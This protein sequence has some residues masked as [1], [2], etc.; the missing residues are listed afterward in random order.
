MNKVIHKILQC[1][2]DGKLFF[3]CYM[4]DGT[5]WTCDIEGNNWSKI[6][7]SE[8]ELTK[9]FNEQQIKPNE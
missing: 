9:K 2:T 1:D 8:E 7:L 6:E 5:G 3:H 4:E